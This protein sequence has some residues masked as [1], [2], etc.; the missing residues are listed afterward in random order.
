MGAQV[1]PS[2]FPSSCQ[3][4]TIMKLVA[5]KRARP[6]GRVKEDK[7]IE[8]PLPTLSTSSAPRLKSRR[9][10]NTTQRH[11]HIDLM[12]R[13][14]Q[15]PTDTGI[16]I[17]INGA[18]TDVDSHPN[19]EFKIQYCSKNKTHPE[20]ASRKRAGSEKTSNIR[21]E[22]RTTHIF[23]RSRLASDC[24]L[25]HPVEVKS[26]SEIDQNVQVLKTFN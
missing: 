1:P 26:S 17:L 23:P 25:E 2:F 18:A 5:C 4:L 16:R 12:I 19:I 7:P 9:E 14:F 22:S 6:V 8:L 11:D 10:F 13:I 15:M 3:A 20:S 21:L 24:S